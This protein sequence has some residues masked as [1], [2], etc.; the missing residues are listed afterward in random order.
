MLTRKIFIA[1]V[2]SVATLALVGS[3]EAQGYP[4]HPITMIVP[5]PAGGP[6]D[7]IGRV[8]ADGMRHSLG[9]PIVIENVSGAAGSLGT[10]RIARTEPDGY[11]L[12]LG[13]SV[14]HV[15]NGAV[16][17]LKYDLLKDFAPVILLANQPQLIVA[18]K[19]FPARDLKELIAW[20]K[21]NP[22]KASAGIGGIGGV[23]HVAGVFFE[24][25]TGTKFQF[26]PYRGLGPAMQDLVG[27]QID[28]MIDLAANTL[29]QVRAGT[30]KAYA[31]TS[32]TRLLAAPD[33]PTVDEA[34]LPGFYHSSWHGLWVPQSTP[35]SI[36]AKLNSAVVAAF[37]DSTIRERLADMGQE[38]FPPEQQSP[39]A[40][41]A[42]QKADIEKW[43]P[44]IKAVGL[45]A[46]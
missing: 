36:V 8:V 21:A 32:K 12:F 5:F 37:A 46:Q 15:I 9:Q 3:A 7:T 24:K 41:G 28:I 6:T 38:T 34:G 10:G 33:I 16:Y 42:L 20:L 25:E 22:G 18:K 27:G 31:V 14:T 17:A 44:V 23:S 39:A 2:A 40:L 26:V 4:S 19:D 29:P 11:T 1:S 30:I 13:N 45:R 43:W 35:E